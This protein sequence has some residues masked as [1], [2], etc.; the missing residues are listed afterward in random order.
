[1]AL[2][3]GS[4]IEALPPSGVAVFPADDAQAHVW[5]RQAGARAQLTFARS[6]RADVTGDALWVDDHWMLRTHTP[7]G[8]AEFALHAP[9]AH[10]LHNALAAVTAALAAGA[11]LD[12]IVRGMEAFRPVSGRSRLLSWQRVN[13]SVV[14]VDDSYN[15]NPD[16]VRAAIDLL[17]GLSGPHWLVLGDMGEVGTQGPEFHAEVGAYAK[18][19]GVEQLWLAGA[20]CLDTARAYGPTARHFA[21][22][23]ELIAALH[24]APRCAAALVKGSRFMGMERVVRALVPQEGSS[25]VH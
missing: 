10:N 24:E 19:R 14:L 7:A 6:G 8:A 25:H 15:A 11:P 5:R 21:G 17:M 3:N 12:A 20:A 23:P 16:S 13:D 22:T 9:G 4:A 18:A 2:E 1:V